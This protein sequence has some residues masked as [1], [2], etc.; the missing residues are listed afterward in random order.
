MQSSPQRN[1]YQPCTKEKNDYKQR[2]IATCYKIINEIIQHK[3]YSHRPPSSRALGSKSLE[4]RCE[5]DPHQLVSKVPIPFSTPWSAHHSRDNSK[6]DLSDLLGELVHMY[7]AKTSRVG[8]LLLVRVVGSG[9]RDQTGHLLPASIYRLGVMSIEPVHARIQLH[10]ELLLDA[11][12]IIAGVNM[13]CQNKVSQRPL[14]VQ[15]VQMVSSV[16]LR[17]EVDVDEGAISQSFFDKEVLVRLWVIVKGGFLL[18]HLEIG[19]LKV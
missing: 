5:D 18:S 10:E 17:G 12:H 16:S 7:D 8:E 15:R 11:S 9:V 6:G 1:Y 19:S 2:V 13:R 3:S 14:G 4:F